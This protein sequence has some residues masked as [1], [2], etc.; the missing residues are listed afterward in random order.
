MKLNGDFVFSL[1]VQILWGSAAAFLSGLLIYFKQKELLHLSA[2]LIVVLVLYQAGYRLRSKLSTL[3][4]TIRTVAVIVLLVTCLLGPLFVYQVRP[5]TFY[6]SGIVIGGI[7]I[8]SISAFALNDHARLVYPRNLSLVIASFVAGYLTP[9]Q[10][11]QY[12]VFGLSVFVATIFF[13][14]SNIKIRLTVA[15][16]I[17]VIG[18]ALVIFQ[19]P[20]NF[21]EEQ[22]EYDDKVLY[23]ARTQ[24][25]KVVITQWQNDQWIFIDGLKNISSIDE[26]LFYEPMAHGVFK[27]G[28]NIKHVL[29][30]GGENGCLIREILKYKNV[31]SID[32]VSYDTLLRNIG[33]ENE[34]LM[35]MNESSY[36]DRRVKVLDENITDFISNANR[37]Y[38]AVFID[39]PDP[40]SI[41]T[42]QYYTLE[43]YEQIIKILD[44]KGVMITQAGSPY[45]ASK[46]YFSI[47][48]TIERAGFHTLPL[49][50]QILTLGEWGW[51]PGSKTMARH[52]MKAKLVNGKIPDVRTRWFNEEAA[53]LVSAF[54]KTHTDTLNIGINTFENPL[55]YQY[56]LKGNWEL[57]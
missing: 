44:E 46:A 43:F 26:Y 25:H 35:R 32:V 36:S 3:S 28:E 30:I 33:M 2:V 37:S 11:L 31:Q 29:V 41:E 1:T 49:H 8:A 55:V 20:L 42:N 54:G 57:N 27:I 4:P 5:Y 12:L 15:G 24:F 38:H 53:K 40:R 17:A 52:E 19:K 16:S 45:F 51:F 39:L 18:V 14:R 10:I 22:A 13:I 7:I 21:F 6:I 23:A 56:Y 50:N 34:Y 47:G 48:K 9:W